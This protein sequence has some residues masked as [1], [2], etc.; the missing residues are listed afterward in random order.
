MSST[1]FRFA[2]AAVGLCMFASAASMAAADT[3]R[4]TR[5]VSGIDRIVLHSIGDLVVTQADKESLTIEAEARLLPK[6]VAEVKGRTLH[7]GTTEGVVSTRY[8]VR[9]L[10]TVKSLSGIEARGSGEVAIPSLKADSFDLALAGSGSAEIGTLSAESLRVKLAGA[11]GATIGGGTVGV[12]TIAITGSSSYTA[13]KLRSVK[14][15]LEI[16]G[17]G[18][19]ELWATDTLDVSIAGSGDVRYRGD[20]KVTRSIAGSGEVARVSGQ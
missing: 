6:I 14:S 1:R 15:S 13:P 10:L 16:R 7:F 17:S 18:S 3:A 2:A 4:E 9:F 11:G 20:P 12:Q 5:P 8:P 19:V